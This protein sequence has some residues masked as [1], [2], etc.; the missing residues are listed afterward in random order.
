MKV[1]NHFQ[2]SVKLCEPK[3]ISGQSPKCPRDRIFNVNLE[4]RYILY[5]IEDRGKFIYLFGRY[6][7]KCANF[8]RFPPFCPPLYRLARQGY[9]D[10]KKEEAKVEW[11]RFSYGREN[12]IGLVT[13]MENMLRTTVIRKF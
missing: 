13:N 10:N 12:L 11:D 5:M 2:R 8:K 6:S 1:A 4:L 7:K 9:K 3:T